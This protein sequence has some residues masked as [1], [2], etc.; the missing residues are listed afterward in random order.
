MVFEGCCN[1]AEQEHVQREKEIQA[2]C[3]SCFMVNMV[4]SYKDSAYLYMLMECVMGGEL[5]TYLQ[6]GG[7]PLLPLHPRMACSLRTAHHYI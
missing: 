1:V 2:E 5:F 3:N 4:A 7:P 6:V